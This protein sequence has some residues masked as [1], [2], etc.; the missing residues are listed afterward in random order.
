MSLSSMRTAI[1][2]PVY[3]HEEA[4]GLTLQAV[5]AF[6]YPILLVDDGSHQ[7]CQRVL[8]SLQHAHA[9][10]VMLLRR[11]HNGGKGA[12]VKSGLLE[13]ERLGFTHAVQ[14]DAD[15]QHDIERLPQ[16]LA[17]AVDHP[18]AL[19]SGY[20][21]YD[22]SVP[23]G[24]YLARYLTHVWV[25]INTLSLQIRDSMCGF[26]VY[27]VPQVNQMLANVKTGDRMEF[28]PELLVHWCWQ[29]GRLINIP[30]R[31]HYPLD[32]VSHFRV[33]HDNLLISRMHASLFFGML[34]RLPRLLQRRLRSGKG[35][36][37]G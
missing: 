24:R 11:T 34:W 15:G 31:V 8:E 35:A 17:A 7:G 37:G 23:K 27:P 25:W 28:D 36:P 29:G 5:M 30:V 33:L 3:N 21:E 16:L 26:R 4:I 14:V 9:E 20:P 1:L 22:D 10:Q 6:G 32:G 2:I 19:V 13:L 12:A 18:G